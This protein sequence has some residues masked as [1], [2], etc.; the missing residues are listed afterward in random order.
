MHT[1][2][3][4]VLYV[5]LDKCIIIIESLLGCKCGGLFSFQCTIYQVLQ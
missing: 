1:G 3:V 2:H 4:V 5:D